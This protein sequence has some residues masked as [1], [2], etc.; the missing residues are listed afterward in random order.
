MD[1]ACPEAG[2]PSHRVSFKPFLLISQIDLSRYPTTPA[3]I[4]LDEAKAEYTKHSYDYRKSGAVIAAE[5]MGVDPH[6]VIKTLVM[7]DEERKPFIVLMHAEKEVSLKE[8]ARELGVKYVSTCSVHDAQR[9]SGYIVGGISPFGTRRELPVFMEK[10]ILELPYLY[11]NG[12]RRGFILGMKPS[13]PY[14]LLDAQ[15]IEAA[16]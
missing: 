7:E 14:R 11:V 12:G 16:R 2:C 9:Y 5:Q 13:A 3:T 8:L 4:F 1:P 6:A 10:S 15:I